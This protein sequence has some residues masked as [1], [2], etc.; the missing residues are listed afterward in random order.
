MQRERRPGPAA[1]RVPVLNEPPA[2]LEPPSTVHERFAAELAAVHAQARDVV[3]ALL[4]A[5]AACA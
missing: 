3:L 4:A 2:A 1:R 5:P